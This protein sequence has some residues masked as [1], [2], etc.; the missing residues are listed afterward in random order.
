MCD[1]ATYQLLDRVAQAPKGATQLASRVGQKPIASY[2]LLQIL[3]VGGLRAI[4]LRYG[5][6]SFRLGNARSSRGLLL[7]LVVGLL[8]GGGGGGGS[9]NDGM[10]VT[11]L[12]S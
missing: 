8:S 3:Q 11:Q 1:C 5:A 2:A 9:H 7:G 12:Q 6:L 10:W 4:G